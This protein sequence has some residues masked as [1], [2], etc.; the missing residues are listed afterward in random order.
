MAAKP[1]KKERIPQTPKWPTCKYVT[2]IRFV[3]K[4][5]TPHLCERKARND[6]FC[7]EPTHGALTSV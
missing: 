4:V 7:D 3:K 2:G 6:G 5:E 1:V